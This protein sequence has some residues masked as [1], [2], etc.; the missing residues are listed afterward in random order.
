MTALFLLL[1]ILAGVFFGLAAGRVAA[2][3]VDFLALGLLAWVVVEV[4][5]TLTK[6]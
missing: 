6:L 5:Q 2:R 1:Y 3:R 4:L